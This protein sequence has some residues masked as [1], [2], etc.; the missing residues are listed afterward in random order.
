MTPSVAPVDKIVQSA[1]TLLVRL[2]KIKAIGLSGSHAR[3]MADSLSDVDLC[4]YVAGVIPAAEIRREAYH[5]LGFEKELYFDIDFETS[6]GDG[7]ELY[8][9]RCD[10]NWMSITAVT[11]FLD[12]LTVDFDSPEWLPGG[13]QTVAPLYDPQHELVQLQHNIPVYS[14]VRAQHRLAKMLQE[15]HFTLYGLGWLDKAVLRR[16]VFSFQKY[17]HALLQNLF[18]ILYALNQQ[19][20]SDEKRLT[21]RIMAFDLKPIQA[22]ERIE[23]IIMYQHGNENLK[24]CLANIKSLFADTVSLVN[25]K[26]PE[27]ECPSKWD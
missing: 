26:Y 12:A 24:T 23:N 4:I 8:G 15:S 13:L 7:F 2:E 11:D 10:F 17:Q 5:T 25:K 21:K 3:H 18:A 14:D 9:E 20:F 6:R 19:W 27:L 22:D 1:L 16:D